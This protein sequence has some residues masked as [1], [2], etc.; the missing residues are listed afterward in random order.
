MTEH[1]DRNKRFQRYIAI[2]IR[3]RKDMRM[4]TNKRDNGKGPFAHDSLLPSV[5]PTL[6][7]AYNR[8]VS[9]FGLR[10]RP[11]LRFARTSDTRQPLDEM[12]KQ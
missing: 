1:L 12:L 2:C 10:L 3:E 6:T 7:G 11:N 5:A 4:P 9:G 8:R